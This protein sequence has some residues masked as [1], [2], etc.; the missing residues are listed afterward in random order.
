PTPH[1]AGVDAA[2][3]GAVD[4][5]PVAST[6]NQDLLAA[7]DAEE[8]AAAAA[9]VEIATAPE[10]T[11]NPWTR[12]ASGAIMALQSCSGTVW[13]AAPRSLPSS[14]GAAP[15]PMIDRDLASA[16]R[17]CQ[18]SS[19]AQNSPPA[20]PQVVPMGPQGPPV[21]CASLRAD[22]ALRSE[23]G[24]PLW[25]IG[26]TRSPQPKML[27]PP[28]KRGFRPPST[29]AAALPLATLL[30]RQPCD[31]RLQGRVMIRD[32]GIVRHLVVQI[33]TGLEQIVDCWWRQ[34]NPTSK[35]SKKGRPRVRGRDRAP[36]LQGVRSRQAGL[37]RFPKC[38]GQ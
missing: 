35:Q 27:P 2:T 29:H 15:G 10:A 19:A 13:G 3:S 31:R 36:T 33:A 8:E 26:T 37:R 20:P 14:A 23:D 6:A 22:R 24:S 38:A 30:P 4:L 25:T 17:L 12:S 28:N 32:M 18:R 7:E 1:P 21:P 34:S 5:A 9:V 11:F 16:A